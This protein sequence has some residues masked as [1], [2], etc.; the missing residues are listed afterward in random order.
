VIPQALA[1]LNMKGGVG[2]TSLVANIAGLIAAAEHGG[3]NRVLAVDLDPQGS[4]GRDL[5]YYDA[6]GR[7]DKGAG[8]F[9]A[10]TTGTSL[11]PLSD[12]RPGLDVI[13]GGPCLEDLVAVVA[14]QQARGNS[15]PERVVSDALEGLS[16]NYGLVL[17]DCPPG[18]RLL[19]DIALSAAHYVL[20]P[21]KT[22]DASLDGLAFVAQRFSIARASSNPNLQLLGVVMFGV[23]RGATR[24]MRRAREAVEADLGDSSLMLDTTIRH[25]EAVAQDARRRGQLVHELEAAVLS[26]DT[27]W[28]R[29]RAGKG[30]DDDSPSRSAVGL[31]EDYQNLASELLDRL[32]ALAPVPVEAF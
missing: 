14:A 4:L 17:I 18:S 23:G 6:E 16:D 10:A 7:D 30:S 27:W 19:I 2:K 31:A 22:D 24:V 32:Q 12:V 1:V 8:L 9:A 28:Q 15:S 13:A 20:I 11:S 26:A 5:G 25:V 29:R 21:T 3:G